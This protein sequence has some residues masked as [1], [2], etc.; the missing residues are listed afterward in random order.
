MSD[1]VDVI[2]VGVPGPPGPGGTGA[3]SSV[4]TQTGHVVLDAADVGA[5][6][7]GTASGL[8]ATEAAARASGDSTNAAAIAAE[9]TARANADTA[10]D[11]RVDVLEALDPVLEGDSRLTDARTPTA[12]A[13]SHQDGGSDELALD[14]SQITSGT[15]DDARLPSGIA[16]DTEVTSAVSTHAAASDPHGDRA[17]ATSAVST[18]EADTTN[19]HGIA[20]TSAL[21]TTTGAQAKADAKVSDTAYNASSW[22]AVTGVAPSKNAVRDKFETLGALAAL[23][24]VGSAQIDDGSVANSD[25]ANMTAKTFKGRHT[26]STG[27]PEDVS[28]AN[29]LADLNGTEHVAPDFSATGLTGATSGARFVGATASGSPASGTFSVGDYVVD[30]SG[31]MWVCTVAGSPGTWV[32]VGGGRQL[33]F[34][35]ITTTPGT[36]NGVGLG[37]RTDLDSGLVISPVV[38]TRPIRLT[39]NIP[40]ISNNTNTDGAAVCIVEGTIGGGI[41]TT[42]AQASWAPTAGGQTVPLYLQRI[43]SPSAGSHT[44]KA[45]AFVI[46]G[47]TGTVTCSTV[48]RAWLMAEEI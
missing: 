1:T 2:E 44:Y 39:L 25:L 28:V 32:G 31:Q 22:D 8:V 18:H 17:F 16:R 46:V 19:V 43:I 15:V 24:T 11:G 37:N 12:H 9:A 41:G 40:A 33:A 27:A 38:G 23:N 26:N 29:L 36:F 5:D 45:M 47:G 35:E 30:Q 48:L 3:V 34:A 14:G 21:E 42:L 20:D 6:P 7:A 13:T 4:N 10:L